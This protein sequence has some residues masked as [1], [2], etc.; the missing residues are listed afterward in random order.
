MKKGGERE[1]ETSRKEVKVKE[2]RGARSP[3][4]L[5]VCDACGA[6]APDR[7]PVRT[8][9]RSS[10]SGAGEVREV[11]RHRRRRVRQ[12]GLPGIRRRRHSRRRPR[13]RHRLLRR[14]PPPP[15]RSQ[16]AAQPRN[17]HPERD[18][19]LRLQPVLAPLHDVL[20]PLR[21]R[22]HRH[23]LE[24]RPQPRRLLLQRAH[25]LLRRLQ[26]RRR[27]RRRPRGHSGHRHARAGGG[28]RGSAEQVEAVQHLD[29][30][31]VLLHDGGHP[32]RRVGRRAHAV[33]PQRVG[34]DA[35]AR[36][37]RLQQP[38]HAREALLPPRVLGFPRVHQLLCVD[39]RRGCAACRLRRPAAAAAEHPPLSSLPRQHQ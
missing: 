30:P 8:R 2:N 31:H 33:L 35:D 32:R 10:R 29:Q 7:P 28:A 13:R 14:A 6:D 20:P 23:R 21:R 9:P 1:E 34:L 37:R 26:R 12:P 22:R 27:R 18:A 11:R 38:H 4:L 36:E 3:S 39:V 25:P 16:R 19:R 17:L 5:F 15:R 24:L